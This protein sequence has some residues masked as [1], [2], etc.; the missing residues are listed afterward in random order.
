M[1]DVAVVRMRAV[2]VA[3][4]INRRAGIVP[5]GNASGSSRIGLRM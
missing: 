1:D 2:R 3:A 5:R 4:L